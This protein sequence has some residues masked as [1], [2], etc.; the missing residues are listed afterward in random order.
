MSGQVTGM[1][2]VCTGRATYSVTTGAAVSLETIAGGTIPA[3]SVGCKIQADGGT[4]RMR[5]DNANP[6]AAIGFRLDDGVIIDVDTSLPFVKL[7]AQNA[8][9]TVQVEFY[10]K[11]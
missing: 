7:I 10:D 11:V 1:T 3:N 9:T 5:S 4:L 2:R 6:T 8:A